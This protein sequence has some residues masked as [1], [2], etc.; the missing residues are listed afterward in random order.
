MGPHTHKHAQV[1][2]TSCAHYIHKHTHSTHKHSFAY[3]QVHLRTHTSTQTQNWTP[4]PGLEWNHS[5]PCCF[6]GSLP[7]L[8]FS[9]ERGGILWSLQNRRCLQLLRAWGGVSSLWRGFECRFGGWP[10]KH[11]QN[12]HSIYLGL[13]Q[14]WAGLALGTTSRVSLTFEVLGISLGSMGGGL[15]TELLVPGGWWVVGVGGGG[16]ALVQCGVPG[17]GSGPDRGG[18]EWLPPGQRLGAL[19]GQP[20]WAQFWCCGPGSAPPEEALPFDGPHFPLLSPGAALCSC[21]FTLLHLILLGAQTRG[22][23]CHCFT[24]RMS[25]QTAHE[26]QNQEWRPMFFLL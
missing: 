14:E 15:R 7:E 10:L 12:F 16:G 13:K 9:R 1:H 6:W 22:R 25:G 17:V 5:H 24:A 2:T 19:R 18:K 20:S 8:L 23:L 26:L 3:M 21:Y 4:W 11:L